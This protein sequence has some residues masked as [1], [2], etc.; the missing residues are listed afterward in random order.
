MLQRFKDG[1]EEGR[2]P[3]GEE[4]SFVNGE[5]LCG[6]EEEYEVIE[7]REESCIVKGSRLVLLNSAGYV[8]LEIE[9][10]KK[11]KEEEEKVVVVVVIVKKE[12]EKEKKL[13]EEEEEE[14]E[15]KE[16]EERKEEGLKKEGG[17][18]VLLLLRKKKRRRRR[19]GVR[20]RLGILHSKEQL[21][22]KYRIRGVGGRR[23]EG[24][25]RPEGGA[26][27]FRMSACCCCR[28]IDDDTSCF[29]DRS[30]SSFFTNIKMKKE[31]DR[32][33]VNFA[34]T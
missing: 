20:C 2:F 13:G 5:W 17:S 34:R 26:S 14:E 24:R 31:T 30:P 10:K 25:G 8:C 18:I 19:T 7:E 32:I 33:P 15:E 3:R 11:K 16:E 29:E 21:N 1:A 27:A 9:N 23:G 12:E 22:D 4:G 6:M 28:D